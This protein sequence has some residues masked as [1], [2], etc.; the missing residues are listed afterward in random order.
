MTMK[1][2]YLPQVE[3]VAEPNSYVHFG[4]RKEFESDRLTGTAACS[5]PSTYEKFREHVS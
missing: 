5:G 4:G 2:N 1:D 3:D